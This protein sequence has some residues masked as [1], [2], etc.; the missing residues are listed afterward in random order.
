MYT[1]YSLSNSNYF[2]SAKTCPRES[3][4]IDFTSAKIEFTSA[5]FKKLYFPKYLIKRHCKQ[6]LFVV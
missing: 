2:K 3:S 1:N 5:I 4:V 6:L